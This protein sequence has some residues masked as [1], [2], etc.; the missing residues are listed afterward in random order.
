MEKL[1][2]TWL[3]RDLVVLRAVAERLEA[4]GN[5]VVSHQLAEELGLTYQQLEAALVAL[6]GE[7]LLIKWSGALGGRRGTG[8]VT[9]MTPAARRATGLWPT[10][11]SLAES[12][13]EEIGK[14]LESTDD[15]DTRSRLVR[16]RDAVAGAGRDLVVDVLG[17]VLS[18]GITGG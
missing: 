1:P 10:P 15:P 9:G 12:L 18:R 7:Y 6:E 5:P 14:A 16:I 13:V 2:D 4:D 11:E 3:T 17:A 8:I